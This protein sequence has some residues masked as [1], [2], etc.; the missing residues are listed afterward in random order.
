[1]DQLRDLNFGLGAG[2]AVSCTDGGSTKT[3][4]LSAGKRYVLSTSASGGVHVVMGPQAS[5]AAAVT[6]FL[7]MP[8]APIEV[9]ATST[10]N[11]AAGIC[12]SGA[13]AGTLIASPRETA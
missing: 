8:A 7:L 11:A 13:A 12:P 4:A 9:E 10:N 2:V 6:D 5:V 1:M 3:A